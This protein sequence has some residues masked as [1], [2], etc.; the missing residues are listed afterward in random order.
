MLTAKYGEDQMGWTSGMPLGSV[1]C[2]IWKGIREG[3]KSLSR[4]IRLKVNNGENVLFW[5]DP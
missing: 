5:H 4:F 1:S 3:V 2:G